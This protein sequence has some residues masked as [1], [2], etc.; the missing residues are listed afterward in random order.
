MTQCLQELQLDGLVGPT[1][2]FG[3]LSIGNVASMAHAGWQSHPRQA[4]LQ[5]L[6]KMR[7][8]VALGIPQAVLP[9][10]ERPDL[11]F[12]RQAGF[13]GCDTE[14]IRQAA[15]AEPYLL[16]LAMSSAFMWTANA[17]TVIP[18][19]DSEDSRTHLVV[20]NLAATSHRAIEG[21]PR[22]AMLR[23]LFTNAAQVVIHNPLF[24]NPAFCDEGAANH[25][26]LYGSDSASG[27]HLFVY[28]RAH[29]MPTSQL[30]G[31][32]PARQTAAASRAVARLGRLPANRVLFV[33]Q[34]AQA[35]DA[36]AFHNDVVMVAHGNRLLLHEYCLV[37]QE[38]TIQTI[39]RHVPELNVYQTAE[40]DLSLHQAV[41]SYLFNSQLLNVSQGYVLLA[42]MQCS[43]G[44]AHQITQR[45][46][47]EGFIDQVIFQD[48]DQS[49]AG[50]GGPACLRLRLPLN[51]AELMTL[52]PGIR[53]TEVKLQQLEAWVNRHYRDKL[54]AA[55]LADPCLLRES[56]EALDSLTQLLDLGAI[57]PF[58][59]VLS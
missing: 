3:G 8:V 15:A 23:R 34:Q 24:T 35:I 40:S 49:M 27:Y 39:R 7:Q 51:K 56:R 37:D 20:A 22:A 36:G 9:P 10:L 32:F 17:A 30:P 43:S 4:A 57:Y 1:H 45:L 31:Q 44:T 13:K 2:H 12:L 14:V 21:Q 6:A 58:Q 25:S 52:A 47:D 53:L 59:Q 29:D 41:K 16:H 11:C 54:A 33:R 26:R 5:G 28:G 42:P 46:L 55:D 19:C 38:N 18:S 50:G 48:L